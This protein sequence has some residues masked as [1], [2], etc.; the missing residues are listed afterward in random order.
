[1]AAATGFVTDSNEAET[2]SLEPPSVNSRPG[3]EYSAPRRLWQGIPGIERTSSGR[4]LATWYSGGDNEGPENYILLGSS[5]DDGRTWS[6]PL[7]V[8]HPPHPVRA[9]DPVLWHD[10]NGA[11]WWFWS[12]SYGLFDGRAGVWCTR[13][14][15]SSTT[16]LEWTT[17]R[18]IFDGIMMNKPTVLESG[19]WLAPGAIWSPVLPTF[20]VRDDMRQLR[21]SNVYTSP[22]GG[23]SW[24]LQG[25]ADVPNRHFDEH[26]IVERRDGSLWMLVRTKS[27][28][29]EAISTDQGKT[30]KPSKGNVLEGP[31]SR[32]FIRRLHSGR[33]LL[34]NHYRFQER[35]NLTAMLSDDEGRTWYGHLVLDERADVSYPDGAESP[36][37]V[38]YVVYDRERTQAKEI[39]LATF[40]E[41]DVEAGAAVTKTCRL[42]QIVSRVPTS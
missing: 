16:P 10:P 9:F 37:G 31:C 18:R 2:L 14:L 23:G 3:S 19:A 38:C 24:I 28:I 1:M 27:G 6:E 12:Q 25:H 4:L 22:D 8:I 32:F 35:N 29:G 42:K 34:V 36:E 41:S 40:T 7:H 33:L 26:M 39:L 30:W 13:C 20:V 17:P 21:F 15:S 11:L 5:E